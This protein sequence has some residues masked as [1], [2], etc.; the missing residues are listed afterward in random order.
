MHADQCKEKSPLTRKLVRVK[1]N[2]G[3]GDAGHFTLHAADIFRGRNKQE[4]APCL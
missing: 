2:I 3:L 4:T 1:I